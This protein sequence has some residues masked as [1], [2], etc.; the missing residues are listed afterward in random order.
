MVTFDYLNLVEDR[1][2]SLTNNTNGMDVILCRNVTIYFTPEVTKKVLDRFYNCLTDGAW[3][4]PGA[5]GPNMVFYQD[6]ESRNFPGAVLYQKPAA[7]RAK[8]RPAPAFK[9]QMPAFK[10]LAPLV[11]APESKPFPGVPDVK[12]QEKPQPPPPDP[13]EMALALLEAGQADEAL[14]KL[15]EKLDQAPGFAPTYYTLAVCR[16]ETLFMHLKR[17]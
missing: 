2:P 17:W 13:Y 7:A 14:V 1:Y 9:P 12:K 3:L 5:S 10:P 16:S 8:A 6:F 15:Y 11:R 4:I